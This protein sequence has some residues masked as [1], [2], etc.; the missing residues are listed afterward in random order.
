[1]TMPDL[2]AVPAPA[3]RKVAIFQLSNYRY[4]PFARHLANIAPEFERREIQLDLLLSASED[5]ET[6]PPTVR[7]RVLGQWCTRIPRLPRHYLAIF[8]LAAYFRKE[9]PDAV[10]CRGVPFAVPALVARAMAS[11]KP[12]IVMTL[13]SNLHHDIGNGIYRSSF[14]L[15]WLARFALACCDHAVPVSEG[16][17][18]SY[19]GLTKDQTKF[20]T[21]HNPVVSDSLLV[22]GAAEAPD[23]WL[24]E[25][26]AFRTLLIVGRLAPEKDHATA[27]RALG[28]LRATDD[29]RLLV[30]G[31]GPLLEQL[32]EQARQVGVQDAVRFLGRLEN[33]YA[34]MRKA[35]ALVLS[36]RTE[37]LPGVLIQAMAMGC[38]VVATDCH[39]GPREILEGGKWGPLVP[40]GDDQSLAAAIRRVLAAPPPPELLKRRAQEFSARASSEK[41]LSLIWELNLRRK[42]R[43]AGAGRPREGS[44]F[45]P[46]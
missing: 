15:R 16:I 34:Y 32:E 39:S 30:I 27:L 41:L 9:A 12:V 8:E 37:G 2:S 44:P 35:H 45:N 36:S 43:T 23:P 11:S 33:P 17:R 19:S 7:P 31:G 4:S 10:I 25:G 26:R 29:V 40:V 5:V 46:P 6:A 22:A 42:A 20:T 18:D 13:H 1:M 28:L 21:I 24:A 3:L 38:P 14:M